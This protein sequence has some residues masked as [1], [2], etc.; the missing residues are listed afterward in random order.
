MKRESVRKMLAALLEIQTIQKENMKKKS[1]ISKV[2]SIGDL[3]RRAVTDPR[4]RELAMIS[5]SNLG[6]SPK[7]L[8]DAINWLNT[9]AMETDEDGEKGVVAEINFCRDLV[10]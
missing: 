1:L 8:D 10:K 5:A 6:G 7:N 3:R 9:N 4:Y 2:V